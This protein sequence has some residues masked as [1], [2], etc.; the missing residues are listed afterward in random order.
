[1][2]TQFY[3]D[4]END[5]SLFTW[6]EEDVLGFVIFLSEVIHYVSQTNFVSLQKEP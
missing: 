2:E 1:V 4:K 6:K 3:G 5:I